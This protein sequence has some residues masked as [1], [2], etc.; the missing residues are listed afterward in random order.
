MRF[1]QS[2]LLL[3]TLIP[4]TASAVSVQ[5]VVE[6]SNSGVSE[7]VILALIERDNTIFTIDPD[8]LLAL[9]SQGVSRTVIL[10]MLKSGRPQS[11]GQTPPDP[12]ASSPVVAFPVEPDTIVVGHGP[13]RPNTSHQI[14]VF[15]AP[16]VVPYLL[17]LPF[18]RPVCSGSPPPA[19][20]RPDSSWTGRF[21]ND[22]MRRFINDPAQRFINNGFIPPGR[23]PVL[24]FVNCEL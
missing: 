7:E 3:L 15:A 19:Y 12:A 13:D 5:E 17:Y 24:P 14:D 4:A 9:Q 8:Q 22:P 21:M 11:T 23:P 20:G 2:L 16:L 18:S 10:A 6:L 1:F